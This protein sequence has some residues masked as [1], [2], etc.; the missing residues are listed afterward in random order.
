MERKG[1]YFAIVSSSLALSA[2][3]EGKTKALQF[4]C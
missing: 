3:N 4:S 2:A 1:N